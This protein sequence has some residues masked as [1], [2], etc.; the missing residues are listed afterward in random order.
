MRQED[1]W[2]RDADAETSNLLD[3]ILLWFS[4]NPDELEE[5]ELWRK[6][7]GGRE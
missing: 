7:K 4:E 3:D 1:V 6:E 2:K 5:F